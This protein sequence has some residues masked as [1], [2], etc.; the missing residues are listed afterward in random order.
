MVVSS[1]GS[2]RAPPLCSACSKE[3]SAQ[4]H[5]QL[6][7]FLP[8]VAKFLFV[9]VPLSRAPTHV[10]GLQPD[11]GKERTTLVLSVVAL[12]LVSSRSVP[13]HYLV[14]GRADRTVSSCTP[15]RV[16]PGSLANSEV[17]ESCVS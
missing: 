11:M 12:G 10:S 9:G 15:L 3:V 16:E 13:S 4:Q 6:G 5:F 2:D 17:G 14:H 7:I 8:A 1:C